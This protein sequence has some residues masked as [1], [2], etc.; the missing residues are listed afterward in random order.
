MVQRKVRT[1]WPFSSINLTEGSKTASAPGPG[2]VKKIKKLQRRHS[3]LVLN[4][5][6]WTSD[7]TRLF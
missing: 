4:K 7:G 2:H 1:L 5:T 3:T 6:Q